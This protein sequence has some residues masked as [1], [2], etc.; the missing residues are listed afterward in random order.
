M[1]IEHFAVADGVISG[2]LVNGSIESFND[3]IIAFTV[4]SQGGALLSEPTVGTSGM[5]R[6]TDGNLST[7]LIRGPPSRA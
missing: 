7:V 2:T 6:M 4:K 5:A 3:V 1:S